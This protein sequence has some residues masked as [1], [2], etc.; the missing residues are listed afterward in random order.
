MAERLGA[1]TAV[2]ARVTVLATVVVAV[3]LLASGVV[4]VGLQRH[5]LT[6]NLDDG[7]DA[8]ATGIIA[9]LRRSSIPTR[10]TPHGDEDLVAQLV[11]RDGTVLAASS[12]IAGA[13]E[14]A[15]VPLLRHEEGFRTTDGVSDRHGHYRLLARS[16]TLSDGRPAVLLLAAPLDDVRASARALTSA[17]VFGVPIVAVVLAVVVW[18]LVG[19][20]LSRVEQA[21]QR[22]R[23]FVADAAHELR[24][25]L[26]R[27]RAEVEVDLAHPATADHE[28]TA[29]SVLQE[30]A[31]L[32]RLVEDLLA[33]A[34][35][36]V[37]ANG[38]SAPVA[39]D[40]IVRDEIGR[41]TASGRCRVAID[42]TGVHAT[43]MSGDAEAFR[44]VVR[45][46]LDNAARHARA[47]VVVELRQASGGVALRVTDDGP[48]IAPADRDRVFQ[49]FTRLDE[50]RSTDAGGAG[51]GLAIA[52]EIVEGHSGTIRAS[53]AHPGAAYPGAAFDV[54]LPGP[55]GDAATVS[56]RS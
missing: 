15:T 40:A 43:E 16:I 6:A 38:R 27:M 22:Q 21:T 53:D 42:A 13:P 28:A 31:A 50:E 20:M 25:P 11:S 2:R 14:I 49:P 4:L 19:R 39:L 7:L 32:Q 24:T 35:G 26:T 30:L 45:N 17:L 5:T 37:D 41:V 33:L 46:L 18:V 12:S 48:G 9:D 23:R 56:A 1:T 51:L 29:R 54:L 10:L 47:S 36:G 52:K 55:D 8:E 34:R 44:L 3:V